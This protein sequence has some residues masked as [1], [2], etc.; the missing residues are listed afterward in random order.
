[1]MMIN[2][3]VQIQISLTG[4]LISN[5]NSMYEHPEAIHSCD[6]GKLLDENTD[7]KVLTREQVYEIFVHELNQ[8]ASVYPRTQASLSQSFGQFPPS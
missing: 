8:D 5:G 4:G 6:I 1:M 3:T 2:Q 7:L